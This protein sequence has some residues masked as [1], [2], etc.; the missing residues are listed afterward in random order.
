[1]A[2][3]E[4]ARVIPL[5]DSRQERGW[6][7]PAA[8]SGSRIEVGSAG[9]VVRDGSGLEYLDCGGRGGFLLGHRHPRVAAAVVDQINRRPMASGVLLDPTVARAA[10]TLAEVAP[11]GLDFVHFVNSGTEAVEAAIKLARAL[12]AYRLVA[13]Y[14]GSHGSTLGALSLSTRDRNAEPFRPLLP[15]VRQVPYGDVEALGAVLAD[16]RHHCVVLEPVQA[17]HGVVLPPAGYLSAVADMCRRHGAFLVLDETRT[18][19]GRLGSWWGADA[20][21]VVPDALCVGG[22]LSGGVVPVAALLAT[23][24]GRAPLTHGSFG[25]PEAFAGSPVAMAAAR[26]TV[27]AIRDEGLVDRAGMLGTAIVHDLRRIVAET[28][29]HLVREVRGAGLLIGVEFADQPLAAEFTLELLDRRVLATRAALAPHVVRLT[30]PAVLTDAELDWLLAAAT[31]AARAVV[32]R[33]AEG[34][35]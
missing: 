25:R 28:C 31:E 27:R 23:S 9:A 3:T 6:T 34:V 2:V 30:P 10:A 33:A 11:P 13:A 8:V 12:G 32:A 15:S 26:A 7:R 35:I 14:G 29:P 22:T 16:G 17:D 4:P 19:L 5:H 1:V 18:G 24:Q 21:G 20:E